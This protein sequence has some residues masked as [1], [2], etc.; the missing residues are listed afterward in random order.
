MSLVH[1]TGTMPSPRFPGKLREE[2][3]NRRPARRLLLRHPGDNVVVYGI[4][5]RMRCVVFIAVIALLA[6]SNAPAGQNAFLV[7]D[8]NPAPPAKHGLKE[9]ATAL[10][11]RGWQCHTG[12][13]LDEAEGD[14]IVVAGLSNGNGPAAQLARSNGG[15]LPA[16]PEALSVRKITWRAMPTLVICGSD[17]RGLMY[18]VLD[19]ADRI[20]WSKPDEDP[21]L[22]VHDVSETP[23]LLERSLSTYTMQQ[24][25]F[26]SRLFDD[27]Y[28][29]RYFDL[30]ARCRFNSFVVIFG[31]ENGGFMAPPYPY[32]FDV[33]G[34]PDVRLVGITSEKQKRN[35]Q[36]LK[37]LIACAHRHGIDFVP[38]IWDHIYRGGVQGGGIRG[39][40]KTPQQ[41]TAGLVWGVTADNLASYN[42]AAIAKFLDVFPEIDGIQFRMHGES[43]LKR[44]EIPRFW[45]QVFQTIRQKRPEL[46]VDIRAK[47]LPDEVINDGLE[48]GVHLRVATKYWMEQMGLPF[49]PT[50][51]NPPNQHDRRH[52][53]ADLLTYPQRYKV[54]WRMWNG[55]TTRVLLWGDP[56]YAR[57]FA[58]SAHVYSGD[59]FEVNE[60][61]ATKMLAR[62]HNEAPFELLNA[63]YRHYD[64]EFERY[65]HFYQVFGRLGY[66]PNTPAETW[67]NEFSRRFGDNA[68]P[69]IMQALHAASQV[70]PRIVA[71][72]YRYRYFPTT[73]GWA[74]K[75]RIDD[76][77]TYATAE[78]SD[79][80]QFASFK[81]EASLILEGKE[82]AKRRPVET[83]QWFAR[84]S[85]S[86]LQKVA[87][88]EAG[89]DGTASR[90]FVST[91]TDL[92]IL[93]YLALYHSRRIPAAVSYNLFQE[94]HDLWSLDNAIAHEKRAADA[95][96]K[97]VESAGDVYTDNLA[98]GIDH[99]GLAGHWSDEL[100][101]LR[102]GIDQ[103]EQQRSS[104]RPDL[105]GGAIQ[106]IHVP[107]RRMRPGD[108]VTLRA[109]VLSQDEIEQV[110]CTVRMPT[111]Q[112][113]V[114]DMQAAGCWRYA[115]K[116]PLLPA[117]Q[118]LSYFFEARA[119]SGEGANHPQSDPQ[120]AIEL[121]VSDDRQP[122]RVKLERVT[123][124][125]PGDPIRVSAH[126]TDPS[127][128][129]WVRLRFR[130][131][132]QFEDYESVDMTFD[133][134]SGRYVGDIAAEFV[135]PRWDVMYFVEVMDREGNGRMVPDLDSE[136]PY[137][138]VH[139]QRDS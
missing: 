17:A 114:Y 28:W 44:G 73:R 54:H 29:E 123:T 20:A 23:D 120:A 22:H 99:G 109:T 16:E 34:F 128:V 7:S 57:R 39:A 87:Q 124:A 59:S 127:G 9:L 11:N 106:I 134:P 101:L 118:Q 35:V 26:E 84:T 105:D 27:T 55:G 103:L 4:I 95:W 78:G 51:V 8:S 132:T 126:V 42:R 119:A 64:W 112:R 24:T 60:P 72:S 38:G 117:G 90:E 68:G 74:E 92:K 135:I 66:N 48:Q 116:V 65:W 25:Y 10:G 139:L 138:I 21:L 5:R 108:A 137:V 12:K 83:S 129:R 104:F 41:P 56:D 76:L 81:E 6:V 93:A 36:A 96:Q 61:L 18:A 62:P 32:F 100:E 102:K 37:R 14:L 91:V 86:I 58:D 50:H 53:Y 113:Q 63:E 111:G 43:G 1:S 88:A 30:L 13:S 133:E 110:R 46:R 122:P 2:L 136:M 15:A 67:E 69:Y 3:C 40:N 82:T 75:M 52:G 47:G 33:E 85:D 80:Q 97:L 107:P 77:P 79:V 130:H 45:H 125:K 94:T 70:L 31:Y 19:V 98:M 121:R 71:A 115:V 49:H 131:L 89:I